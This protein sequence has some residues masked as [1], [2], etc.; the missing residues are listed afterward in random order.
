MIL[1]TQNTQDNTA[2]AIYAS[3][4][5]KLTENLI[6]TTALRYDEDKREVTRLDGPTVDTRDSSGVV[7]GVGACDSSA[8]PDNCAV[9]GSKVSETFSAWQPKASLAYV[10]NKHFTYY[11]TYARGFRSGGFNASGALL[12]DTYKEEILDSYELGLKASLYDNRIRASVATFYQDYENVQQF[13]FDGNIFVQSL[14]NIP[15]STITGLEG[16]IEFAATENIT[17]NAAFGIMDSQID[18]FNSDIRDNMEFQL[19]DRITNALPIPTKTQAA[20]DNNFKGAKLPNFAHQTANIG[21]QH[22]LSLAN[23]SYLIT[24]IDYNYSSDRQWWIDGQDH[25]D[26]LGLLDAS[27]GLEFSEG[28]EIRLWCKNCTDETYDSEYSPTERELFG[29]P[30]KDLAYPGKGRTFGLKLDYS[31]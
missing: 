9:S 11:A 21:I 1:S 18:K 8:D 14:Y 29:G 13:E 16:S 31:F 3:S 27:M 26:N 20:F 12:T 10:P 17:L 2:W 25:Q 15:E 6:L 24:R 19:N 28:F 22:E 5:Y 7:R 4:D 23:D 30:A